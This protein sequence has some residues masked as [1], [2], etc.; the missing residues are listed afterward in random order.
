[1]A[2]PTRDARTGPYRRMF[3]RFYDRFQAGYEK[4]IAER[5]RA[6]FA[7][8]GGTVVEIGAGTGINLEY[9]PRSC[10]WIG[11]EP[12]PHMHR[13]LRERARRLGVRAEVRTADARRIDLDDAV[14]DVAL[15]TLVLCSVSDVE[16]TL[17]E[18]RRVLRPGGRFLFLEHVAAPEGTPLRLLQRLLSPGWRLFGDGCRITRDTRPHIEAA[19]FASVEIEEFRVAKIPRW[20]SPH[21]AGTALR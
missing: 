18:V 4:V 7:G 16:E 19:G 15:S 13:P 12:N 9:L 1:M 20:V 17:A 14:A 11:V 3:A 2:S 8:V 5:K 10:R 6:M 21:I